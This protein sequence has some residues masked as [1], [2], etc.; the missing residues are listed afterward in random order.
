MDTPNFDDIRPYNDAELRAALPRIEQWELIQQI[1]R[2]IY[3]PKPV[4]ESLEQLRNVQNVKELQ[5]TFM[6]DAIRRVIE[7]TSDGF[8]CTGFDYIKR[9][10]PHL[11]ISN[12]RDITI[13]AF[14]LQMEFI[15]R[16]RETSYI[17]FG[18][19][20]IDS[21]LMRD[22]FLSNKLIQMDRGGNPMAFYRSLQHLSQYIHQLIVD[23]QQSVWIAQKN[24]RSKDGIDA[25]APAIIKMLTL[26]SS[27]PPLQAIADL[28]IVPLAVSYEWDPCDAMKTH[29]LFTRAHGEYH[30]AEG[31]DTNSVVTGIIGPKGRIHLSIGKPLSVSELKPAEGTDLADHLAALLDRR[32]QRLYHLMPT[33]YLAADLLAGTSRY[34]QHYDNNTKNL[35]LQRM[36][37][38]PSDEHRTIFKQ[39]Y[40][41][42]VL[43][44]QQR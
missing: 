2:F 10:Q 32:I 35:F 8:T 29:E 20:L 39:M 16:G 13:D 33:N 5:T 27:K 9:D 17:V 3:P 44:S 18:N 36:N 22:L 30:K 43:S 24:G 7:T 11:Y 4:E 26:G 28:H 41:N 1:L 21:P 42:P 31:E 14:L 34:R 37:R 19:N 23:Q 38:L 6:Y 40:A 15:R 25:T 12:H